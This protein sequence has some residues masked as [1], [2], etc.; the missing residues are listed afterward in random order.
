MSKF[1]RFHVIANTHSPENRADQAVP[2]FC[3]VFCR[4]LL[5]GCR[6]GV[7]TMCAG[8]LFERA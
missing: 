7:V 4:F 6:Y 3:A 8:G 1:L 5:R 2:V